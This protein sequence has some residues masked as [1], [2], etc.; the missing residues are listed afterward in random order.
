[1]ISQYT[2]ISGPANSV[3]ISWMGHAMFLLEDI[4]GN[5]LV[6]D[7]YNEYVGYKLPDIEAN[8][9]LVSHDHGDHSNVDL[10]K[11][12][13]VIKHDVI[14][15][16]I[17]GIMITGFSSHHDSHEGTERGSN[18]I[19]RW[20]MQGLVFIHLGDL[21]HVIEGNLVGELSGADVL[22][23]PVGGTFTIEDSQA[24][25]VVKTLGPRI[26]V[27]MH[28]RTPVCSL[29][30]QTEEPF[31]ARFDHVERTGKQPLLISK[32]NLPEPIRILVMDYLS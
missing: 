4:E 1:V 10:V 3:R 17:K 6:T 24:E 27:P 8:I 16:E 12:N 9:V 7:P 30:L 23:V 20:E 26:A 5:R 25:Q 14:A 22:F 13:P 15:Q 28:Y 21:G 2:E 31:V 29:P 11:G 32:G 19:F 18:V